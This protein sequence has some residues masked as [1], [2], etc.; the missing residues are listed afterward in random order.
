MRK[1]VLLRNI[2]FF[3]KFE[4]VFKMNR[5]N[6]KTFQNNKTKTVYEII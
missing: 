4:N 5:K 1:N 2:F 6:M 3:H